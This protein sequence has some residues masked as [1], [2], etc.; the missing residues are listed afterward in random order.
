MIPIAQEI[1]GLLQTLP[2]QRAAWF[3]ERLRMVLDVFHQPE[4]K[5]DTS[6]GWPEGHFEQLGGA[7]SD[8]DFEAPDD[9]PPTSDVDMS[10][11]AE[12][13]EENEISAPRAATCKNENLG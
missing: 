12:E 4:L 11:R 13:P 5:T 2:P 7:W 8:L 10:F 6:L 9:P 3:E 1:E